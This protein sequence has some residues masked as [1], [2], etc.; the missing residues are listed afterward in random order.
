MS[1]APR[2][3]L[4]GEKS[5]YLLQHA[6]NPVDWF[7]WGDEAFARAR[8]EDKPIFLSVGYST[9]HWCHVME[10]ESF[11]DPTVAAK[12]RD[13]FIAVKVDR[14]ER[15]DVD[16]VYMTFVQATTGGGGWPMSV[17]L[18]PDLKPFF[19]GTYF[20]P[21]S[22]GGMI[23]FPQLLERIDE[24]WRTRRHDIEESGAQ[25]V[26]EL[27]R[28]EAGGE[29]V[30]LDRG[31]F[32]AAASFFAQTFDKEHGGFGRAPKF[33]RPVV[34]GLLHRVFARTRDPDTATMSLATLH[35]MSRGGMYDHLGGGFHRYSVDRLWHVP[36]FEKMLYDQAQLVDSLVD[37][38]QLTR[39]PE[40]RQ[41][42]RETCDYVLRDL[43]APEGGFYAAEDADSPGP[44]GERR[45]GAFYVWTRAEI[46]EILG[47][48][49]DLFCRA[50][51]V[52]AEGNADDPQG[53]LTGKNVLHA[54]VGP[55]R[56]GAEV[57]RSADDVSA[58]LL[59]ARAALFE[60]RQRRP[61][62]HRD[63][64]VL[65]GWNGLMI[66]ALARAGAAFREP[67]YVRAAD[68]AAA[69]VERALWDGERLRRR[70]AA[71]EA[72][73]D[74]F[75]D[76][77]AFLVR[78]LVEL[79][80][81]GFDWRRLAWAE[82]LADRMVAAFH[83]AAEG[84]F[85]TSRGDDAS[86]LLRMRDDYDGAEPA[87]ASVAAGA[88]FRLAEMLGRDEWRRI[89]EGTVR[90]YSARLK[91]APHAMPEMLSALDFGWE[92]PATIV[93]AG[94]DAGDLLGVV[95]ERFLPNA[96][97]LRAGPELG[98][99]LPWVAAMGPVGGRATAYLCRDHACERPTGDPGELARM[100][101]RLEVA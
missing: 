15:P 46:D 9:C 30:L 24:L 34:L 7:P 32:H 33:P 47:A 88:L 8:A 79:Y 28:A 40:F 83:D 26:A 48:D 85:F 69:F 87:G 81:S 63:E 51:A 65:A 14:E 50:Y 4:A 39:R 94:D 17:F 12:L 55:D 16:R 13:G 82:A 43:R 80:Q 92:P 72:A 6:G 42:A 53:E 86:L 23:G 2:N 35:R 49:A 56:L 101:P 90:F 89:A 61:R 84:G 22:R 45:E 36:H 19:G 52:A 99:R 20:P 97:R 3:R 95:N 78:G 11:E 31:V 75:L 98:A 44:D 71:G 37:A 10:R 74:G 66:G 1:N 18:T 93:V 77:H 25:V 96:L 54:V 21:A 59:A 38:W 58:I 62:P 67:R 57:G 91:A 60:R 29:P 73:V 5:P 70:W 64:K 76:D 68:E 41:V 27:R 100:L